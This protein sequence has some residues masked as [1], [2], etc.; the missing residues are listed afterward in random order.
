MQNHPE[1]SSGGASYGNDVHRNLQQNPHP[2][3]EGH[4][5]PSQ[6]VQSPPQNQLAT[7]IAL[8]DPFTQ[9]YLPPLPGPS[10]IGGG[11]HQ[12]AGSNQF[13]NRNSLDL[14]TDASS[15]QLRPHASVSSSHR[16]L[17]P[18]SSPPPQFQAQSRSSRSKEFIMNPEHKYTFRNTTIAPEEFREAPLST[19]GDIEHRHFPC[20]G[21][22]YSQRVGIESIEHRRGQ[23]LTEAQY[24]RYKEEKEKGRANQAQ[25]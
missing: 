10:A 1:S 8:W 4:Q 13:S 2:H 3:S 14:H 17:L 16:E 12:L 23:G 22:L 18:A 15:G 20:D 25:Q 5:F 24:F 6:A 21:K 19:P 11:G 9:K 7:T